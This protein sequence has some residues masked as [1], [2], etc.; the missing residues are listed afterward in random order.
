MGECITMLSCA[1]IRLQSVPL[2]R[3]NFMHKNVSSNVLRRNCLYEGCRHAVQFPSWQV[4]DYSASFDRTVKG[5][6]CIK[7]NRLRCN[8]VGASINLDDAVN[9]VPVIDQALLMT[10][11]I[12]AYMA[13]AVPSEDAYL[14]AKK[15]KPG[16]ESSIASSIPSG[17]AGNHDKRTKAH[18]TWNEIEGKLVDALDAVDLETNTWIRL[19]E[20]GTHE[21]KDPLSLSAIADGS[22]LRLLLSTLQ[23]LH[24]EVKSIPQVHED[25][26]R[27]VWFGVIFEIIQ[28]S[29]QLVCVGWLEEELRLQNKAEDKVITARMFEKLRNNTILENLK[30]LGKDNLYADFLYFLRFGSLS[31]GCYYDIQLFTQH[32]VDILEDLV[33]TLADGISSIYLELISVDSGLASKMNGLG[34]KL[35]SLSTREL[36]RLRNEVALNQWLQQNFELVVSM[37]EDRFDLSVLQKQLLEDPH[38]SQTEKLM[39]W[40]TF[41]TRKPASTPF[42]LHCVLI[43]QLSLHVKR[44]E[45]LRALIGWRYYYSLFLE[46]SDIAMPLVRVIFDKISS[47]ISFFLKCLIGRSLGLI[48]SGIRQSLGWR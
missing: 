9:W 12:F 41:I 37:Y 4:C 8:V 26:S 7:L 21:T 11:V 2:K 40:K 47:A 14:N 1:N 25:C 39:W 15:H 35:C 45:E 28:G 48:F 19:A 36:Q 32:G 38:E 10:S 5:G 3:R 43:S 24:K 27:D 42:P 13:G 17:R 33:I 34:L 44:T 23:Q 22:R 29:I 6:W 18:D 16:Q 46:F 30:R 31:S 20:H